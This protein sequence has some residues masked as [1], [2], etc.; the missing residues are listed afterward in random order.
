[1]QLVVKIVRVRRDWQHAEQRRV[2]TRTLLVA[3]IP[4]NVDAVMAWS[5]P[6]IEVL[7][8]DLPM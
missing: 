8:L 4:Q 2:R 6:E 1:M 5:N 7:H 3:G